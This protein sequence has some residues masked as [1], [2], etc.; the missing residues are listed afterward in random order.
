MES[1][2]G[3]I[4]A[5][6]FSIALS[7][8]FAVALAVVVTLDALSIL[9]LL[10]A[11]LASLAISV[12]IAVLVAGYGLPLQW[13]NGAYRAV[14]RILAKKA[15]R[16]SLSQ[17]MTPVECL[18]IM[19][20]EGYVQLRLGIGSSSGISEG[21]SFQLLESTD[22][23]QWGIVEVLNVGDTYSD[24]IPIVRSN[25]DFW[26]ALEDRM[27]YDTS[28]PSNIHLVIDLPESYVEWTEWLLD[29]WR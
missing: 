24:C 14:M 6:T 28:A 20:R 3:R 18:G 29:N 19:E 13:V 7:I 25:E 8:A 17:A 26:A 1:F 27:R 9:N 2:S 4:F 10:V 21:F 5:Y 12:A 15:I 23:R 11:I 22:N 16:S